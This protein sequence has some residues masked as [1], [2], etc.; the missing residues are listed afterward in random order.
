M[1]QLGMINGNLS[2]FSFRDFL[3]TF[4]VFQEPEAKRWS[5]VGQC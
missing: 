2:S 5:C 3:D 1:I 4:T